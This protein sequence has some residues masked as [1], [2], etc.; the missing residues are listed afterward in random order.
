MLFGGVSSEV[1]NTPYSFDTSYMYVCENDD[2]QSLDG[3]RVI[4]EDMLKVGATTMADREIVRKVCEIIG[5]RATM[6]VG[7]GTASVVQYMVE[8]GIGMDP[9][10]PGFAICMCIN[11]MLTIIF[12]SS[13]RCTDR[14]TFIQLLVVT[15]TK[16]ILHS[17]REFAKR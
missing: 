16:I 1:L 10:S 6:L 7:A 3:T 17:I 5:E 4:L 9:D 11:L 14:P 13:H 8:H 2:I 12:Q 15:S